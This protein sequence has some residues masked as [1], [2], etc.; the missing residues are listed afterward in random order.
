[1]RV[2]HLQGDLKQS[3]SHLDLEDCDLQKILKDFNLP[4]MQAEGKDFLWLNFAEKALDFETKMAPLMG[5]KSKPQGTLARY[6]WRD[7][8]SF[9]TICSQKVPLSLS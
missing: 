6:A 9:A 1:M 2:A 7:G 4:H 5:M 3:L 8:S